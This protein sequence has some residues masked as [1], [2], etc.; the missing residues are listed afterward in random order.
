MVAIS[1]GWLLVAGV[2]VKSILRTALVDSGY[3]PEH[4]A[5][6]SFA[7]QP[8]RC[9]H[10][11]SE[12][13]AAYLARRERLYR[14]LVEIGVVSYSVAQ[15]MKELGIRAALGADRTDIMVLVLKEGAK[16]ATI[17]SP[18]GFSLAFAAIRVTSNQVVA[19]P[20][21]DAATLLIVPLI[22]AAAILAACCVPARRAARVDP[23]VVLRGL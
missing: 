3:Q 4:A 18:S 21:M 2:S 10:R 6:V 5:F 1:L 9:A 7:L 22:L 12:D 11:S 13:A 17:G 16:V 19:I 15:R 20:A 14:H 8:P 23:M